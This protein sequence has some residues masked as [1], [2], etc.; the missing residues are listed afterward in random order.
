MTKSQFRRLLEAEVSRYKTQ[1]R[2][3]EELGLPQSMLSRVL[4]GKV[5]PGP[6]LLAYF[7]LA[8]EIHYV[9]T[10]NDVKEPS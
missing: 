10:H 1:W 6:T 7:G 8:R 2:A 3:A 4:A 9:K 5:E